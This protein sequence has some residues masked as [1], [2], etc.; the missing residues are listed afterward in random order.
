MGIGAHRERVDTLPIAEAEEA[1]KKQ[2]LTRIQP[3]Q[4]T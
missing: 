3:R 2:Q 1:N 4:E